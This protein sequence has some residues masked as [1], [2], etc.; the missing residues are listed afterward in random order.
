MIGTI[1]LWLAAAV[2]V[3]AGGIAALAAMRAASRA[4]RSPDPRRPPTRLWLDRAILLCL[5]AL[6]VAIA[7]GLI[8]LV[9]GPGPRDPLHFVYAVA[10]PVILGLARW[11]GAS[12]EGRQAWAVAGAG[13][14][15]VVLVIRLAQTGG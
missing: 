1:H 2:L 4:A 6:A 11:W 9:T 5:V 15:V 12:L 13:A 14:I 10:A 3:V 8:V 7:S